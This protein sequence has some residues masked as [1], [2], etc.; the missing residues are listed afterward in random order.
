M[1][2]LFMLWISLGALGGLVKH[3]STTHPFS[4]YGLKIILSG[5]FSFFMPIEK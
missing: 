3:N 2:T 1:F 4:T 5:I